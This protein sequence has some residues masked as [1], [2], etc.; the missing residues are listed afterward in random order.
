MTSLA[1]GRS[2][3]RVGVFTLLGALSFTVLFVHATNRVLGADRSTIF[4]RLNAADGLQRGDAVLLRGVNV[5]EVKALDF[6]AR[7]VIVRVRLTRAVP[8]SDQAGAEL[9]AA[10][11][12]GRQRKSACCVRSPSRSREPCRSAT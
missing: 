10:D 5:G 11:M 1:P 2:A 12:F 6:D 8:L 7:G 3:F 9:V 4:I